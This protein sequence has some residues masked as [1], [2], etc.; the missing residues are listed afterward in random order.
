MERIVANAFASPSVVMIGNFDGVHIGHQALIQHAKTIASGHGWRIIALTFDPHPAMVLRPVPPEH[1]LIT[2]TDVKLY[3]LEQFGVEF[4]KILPFDRQLAAVPALPF[5]AHEVKAA[6][7]AHAVV[8][9]FNFT[10]GAQGAGRA[11]TLIE[12]GRLNGTIVDVVEPVEGDHSAQVVSSS[13]IRQDIQAGQIGTANER[14]GHPFVVMGPVQHGDGRGRTI[15]VPTLNVGV[16]SCQIMPPYGVY[17]GFLRGTDGSRYAAV[18]NW[19]VRPT[20][21]QSLPV[22]EI[23]VLDK[24]LDDW[25]GHRV[26]FDFIEHVRAEQKFDG[27]DALIR[28]IQKDIEKARQL[29][30]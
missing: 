1:F 19:G 27:V 23:H 24:I 22:L 28:Q 16:P 20:F 10:F 5:L 14:L 17:A 6:L 21:G 26:S 9:G 7:N 18:A 4:V 3:W 15:G 30:T 8:V 13:A 11:E 25:Y 29:L 12:W 2:P